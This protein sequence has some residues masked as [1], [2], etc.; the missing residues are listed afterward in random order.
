MI[1][2][3]TAMLISTAIASGAQAAGNAVS[4]SNAK[5]EAKRRA[6]ETKRETFASLLDDAMQRNAELTSHGLSSRG[7][8]GKRKAQSMQDTS[9]LVREA[10][11]V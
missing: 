6:K 5:K 2:P 4:G 11:N 1:D 7:K 9:D 10:F 8:L 3:G